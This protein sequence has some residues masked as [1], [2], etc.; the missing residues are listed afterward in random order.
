[1]SEIFNQLFTL[2][3]DMPVEN[4]TELSVVLR[5][6]M[7]ANPEE[8]SA[9]AGMPGQILINQFV[10]YMRTT[11]VLA[12]ELRVKQEGFNILAEAMQAGRAQ[13]RRS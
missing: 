5:A 11:T 8:L 9:A 3:R 12:D 2:T 1:M 10:V 4:M 13:R 6:R 7:G